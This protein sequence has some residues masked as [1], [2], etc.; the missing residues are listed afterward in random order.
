M[1]D[2]VA[3]YVRRSAGFA[4]TGLAGIWL[5]GCA[6]AS[7]FADSGSPF[8]NPF[9]VASNDAAAPTPHVTS[10]TLAKSPYATA[11]RPSPMAVASAPNPAPATTGSLRARPDAVG[12]SAAGWS[13]VG[14]SP[15][16][17]GSADDASTLSSRYG[18][19]EAA[20]LER[21]RPALAR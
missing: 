9:S 1:S 3:F 13:A 2:C 6:D 4:L 17:V 21:Q 7:R 14:G 16:I 12:G 8:S 18:V 5:S 19:P 10:R 15:V 20:L 11:A